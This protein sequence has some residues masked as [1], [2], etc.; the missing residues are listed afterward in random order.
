[1]T[2]GFELSPDDH[3]LLRTPPPPEALRWCAA[4]VGRRARVVAVP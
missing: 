2:H 3:R 4:A 1:V